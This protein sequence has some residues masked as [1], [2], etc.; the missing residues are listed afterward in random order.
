MNNKILAIT[1]SNSK[2]ENMLKNKGI[3]IINDEKLDKI[4]FYVEQGYE[5]Y[6]YDNLAKYYYLGSLGYDIKYVP[7]FSIDV[8]CNKDEFQ[9]MLD[10]VDE[11]CLLNEISANIYSDTDPLAIKMRSRKEISSNSILIFTKEPELYEGLQE[12][13]TNKKIYINKNPF[14]TEE[15]KV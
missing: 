8:Y 7:L 10:V 9:D 12:E 4:E 13:I 14:S 11:Y 2:C 1:N 3:K 6:I 15:I 5:I